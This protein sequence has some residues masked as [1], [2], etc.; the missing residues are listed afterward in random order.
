MY[1]G[2]DGGGSK[3][4]ISIVTDDGRVLSSVTAPSCYYL[5]GRGLEVVGDVLAKG[6]AE[7][8]SEADIVPGDIAYAFFGLPGYGE[9]SA[10]LPKLDALPASVL[11]HDRYACDNDTVAGWAGSLGADDGI[12]VVSGTGSITY[13][14]RR[15]HGVRIGGWGELFDDEGSGYWIAVRGLSAFAKMS[16]GRLPRGPLHGML[17]EQLD[18]V[19]D[20]DLVDLVLNRWA[21]DRGKIAALSRNVA[22]AADAGDEVCA[23]TLDDAGRTLA[24]LVDVTRRQVEFTDDE[25]VPVSYSGGVFGAPRVRDAFAAELLARSATYELREPLLPPHVGAALYAARL[26]G[27]PLG[28]AAV[29]TLRGLVSVLPGTE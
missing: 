21:G 28:D 1:L 18:L 23:R 2:V 26:A 10:D 20:L 11:G 9:V 12:N 14:E 27:T 29:A 16:D 24:G 4:A 19:T 13:G 8:C 3:T 7:A 25:P 5:G 15:G 22:A 17:R 6:L